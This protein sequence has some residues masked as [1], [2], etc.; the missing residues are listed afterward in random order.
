MKM[1]L[2]QMN[3]NRSRDESVAVACNY[4]D[5]AAAQKPDLIVLPEFF[6]HFY[7][8]QY[9]DH[10]YIDW[11]ECD[12][13]YTI[14]KMKEKAI[15]HNLFIIATIYEEQG[16]GVY[17]DTAIIIDPQGTIIGKY[18]KTHPAARR[19]FEKIYFR[20]GSKYP[21]FNIKD[22][23]VGIVI[24]YDTFFPEAARSVTVNGAE[25]VVIPFASPSFPHNVWTNMLLTRAFENGVYVAAVNKVGVE[26]DLT[27]GGGSLIADPA[28]KLIDKAGD[29]ADETIT[30]EIDRSAV[31]EGRKNHLMLRDRRPDL[32][33]PLTTPT[34]D[35]PC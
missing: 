33:T 29:T 3:S 17:Y 35:L 26:G 25:L 8:F 23:K 31:Y 13:G 28:G 1:A 12:D 21:V 7:F 5:Q 19:G 24:C 11:A 34:E 6:N 22:W 16:P 4:I 20:F 15:E 30:A 18:R 27:F 14:S 32:Y 9:H 10:S 2:I